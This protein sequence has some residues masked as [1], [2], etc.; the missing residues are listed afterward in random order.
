MLL[1]NLE[2]D[3]FKIRRRKARNVKKIF[4]RNVTAS[5]NSVKWAVRAILVS[6]HGDVYMG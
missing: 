4:C 5:L 3:K 1:G 6:E 2:T